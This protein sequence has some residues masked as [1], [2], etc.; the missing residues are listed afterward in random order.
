VGA[1]VL[2][3]ERL[4]LLKGKRV[5]LVTNHTARLASGEHLADALLRRGVVLKR[6]FGPEHGIRG[7][8]TGG[9]SVSDSV[10][11][12]TG[13]PVVSL[14]GKTNKPTPE[15][16][17]DIDVLLYDIQDV[18]ARFYTYISTMALCMEAAASRGIPFVV[19]DRPDPLGG[20]RVDGPVLEDTLRS[21]VGIAPIPVVYGLT[22]GELARLLAGEKMIAGTPD[23]IVVPMKGWRRGMT[24]RETG[25]SWIA[26]SPNIPTPETA[27]AYPATCILEATNL[28]EG[29]G[30]RF[31]FQIFGAPFV[32]GARLAQSL[33]HLELPGVEFDSISFTPTTS[34]HA[35]VLC[36]G[37]SMNVVDQDRFSPVATGLHI[38]REVERLH[39]ADLTI[40]R[41]GF[42]RLMGSA[43]V[44]ERLK[45]GEDVDAISCSW[46]REAAKFGE[47]RE[48]YFLYR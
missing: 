34:K 8:V 11:A 42:L 48:K 33:R 38:L 19:L 3:A 24:W 37:V 18:G 26:P 5:A 14:Y 27:I 13:I 4:D 43:S 35:G 30:T 39:G 16:L 44:Y 22:A 36:H 23:L 2:L 45:S 31:P 41:N 20:N 21:F 28:S 9:E 46:V 12:A 25:L 10:D 47:K 29:R 7:V 17:A 1:D 32:D 6:L 15:M 40:R